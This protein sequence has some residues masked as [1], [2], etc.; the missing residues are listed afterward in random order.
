MKPIQL[1]QTDLWV[2]GSA[3]EDAAASEWQVY[4]DRRPG[5]YP[6]QMQSRSSAVPTT[7]GLLQ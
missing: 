5:G 2:M 4:F 1:A 3:S 6:A 7:Q